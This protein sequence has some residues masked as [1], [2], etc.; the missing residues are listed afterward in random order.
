MSRVP[1]FLETG[2]FGIVG[3]G[4]LISYATVVDTT[5]QCVESLEQ[6]TTNLGATAHIIQL[7]S[8]LH[9]NVVNFVVLSEQS[10]VNC[11]S[12]ETA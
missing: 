8:L 3:P 11:K 5:V 6:A 7:P 9:F 2:I 1:R 4:F 10:R 12:H